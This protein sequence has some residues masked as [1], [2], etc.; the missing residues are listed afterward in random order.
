M[1]TFYFLEWYIQNLWP[2]KVLSCTYS[3]FSLPIRK[4][5]NQMLQH[6][7]INHTL[8]QLNH[9][10]YQ[11]PFSFNWPN[12]N[13]KNLGKPTFHV[14]ILVKKIAWTQHEMDIFSN[15][16]EIFPCYYL[17][18]C[19]CDSC[20]ILMAVVVIVVTFMAH[21]LQVVKNKSQKSERLK[22]KYR[23]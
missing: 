3:V 13:F 15:K 2:Y 14:S 5:F 9:F 4:L 8:Y 1:Q 7:H 20:W 6:C 21:I 12:A 23:L 18:N 16:K 19:S 11:E 17:L 22:P 10:L